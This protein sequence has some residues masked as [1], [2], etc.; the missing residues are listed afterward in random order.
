M[1]LPQCWVLRREK[2]MSLIYNK[3]LRR[4]LRLKLVHWNE[5]AYCT[6]I[7]KALK[8][9]SKRGPATFYSQPFLNYEVFLKS[10]ELFFGQN[11]YT[12]TRLW[13]ILR[14]KTWVFRLQKV[15]KKKK[16]ETKNSFEYNGY[17]T[18]IQQKLKLGHFHC[19]LKT[20]SYKYCPK[21]RT[22]PK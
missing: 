4:H 10:I 18:Y 9:D 14:H 16:T 21:F 8:C 22:C 2:I 17:T 3:V 13:T 5:S 15:K 20:L 19:L 7:D 6:A 12:N 11:E 1:I